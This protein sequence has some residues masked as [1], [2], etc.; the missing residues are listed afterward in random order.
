MIVNNADGLTEIYQSSYAFGNLYTVEIYNQGTTILSSD[1]G[2]DTDS[3]SQYLKFQS[4]SVS[5]NSES[6]NLERND[7][8]K[9]FQVRS[10][11][12]YAW[13]DELSIT[14]READDWRVK[15]YHEEWLDLFYDKSIDRY[16]SHTDASSEGL[17]RN[18]KIKLDKGLLIVFYNVIPKNS[19]DF[20]FSWS[21][22]PNV[23]SHQITYYVEHWQ[24]GTWSN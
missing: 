1:S 8:T 21:D 15:K 20:N 3:M 7:V 19:G 18:I 24:W 17:Y 13:T 22:S 12:A 2:N 10:S 9:K 4:P 11:D 6:L 16:R 5:F 23:V 14:W